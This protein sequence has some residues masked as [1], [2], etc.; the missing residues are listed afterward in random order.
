M[1]PHLV[2]VVCM[3]LEGSLVL[4]G[5]WDHH[6]LTSAQFWVDGH[7]SWETWEE[8]Q[9]DQEAQEVQVECL[10][11]AQVCGWMDLVQGSKDMIL[12]EDPKA[13]EMRCLIDPCGILTDHGMTDQM[14][15][16]DSEMNASE[17]TI[18]VIWIEIV[19][20]MT[21]SERNLTERIVPGMI[22]PETTVQETID[23]GKIDQEMTVNDLERTVQGMI[24]QGMAVLGRIVRGTNVSGMIVQGRTVQGMTV[25][26][27]IVQGMIAIKG[28]IVIG[29]IAQERIDPGVIVFGMIELGTV[30]PEMT[31]TVT[32]DLVIWRDHGKATDTVMI[33]QEILREEKKRDRGKRLDGAHRSKKKQ[34]LVEKKRS[35]VAGTFG[36]RCLLVIQMIIPWQILLPVLKG[37]MLTNRI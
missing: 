19:P 32:K 31:D 13:L 18:D 12:M 29:M 27:K 23:R 10:G 20:E 33:G 7:L 11:S 4:E 8:D 22:V 3:A 28:T 5:Y 15:W 26:E 24:V 1:D 25:L 35:L 30:V 36:L 34:M 2:H 6:Q 16:T 21:I 37:L 9:M 17:M 14:K